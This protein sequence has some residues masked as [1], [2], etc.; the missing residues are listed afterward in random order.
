MWAAAV[1][2]SM[3]SDFTGIRQLLRDRGLRADGEA[4]RHPVGRAVRDRSVCARLGRH[5]DGVTRALFEAR[6]AACTQVQLDP[7]E[8]ALPEL[9][10]GLL[11]TRGVAVVALEAVAAGQAP[12]RLV[13]GLALGESGHDFVEP[14]S[15]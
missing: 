6:G 2:P 5:G 8:P 3:T 11:G 1:L 12:R 14:C 13:T 15:L 9:D 10:N 4:G 7:V